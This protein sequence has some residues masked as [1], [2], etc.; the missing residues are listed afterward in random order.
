MLHDLFRHV[1]PD[2]TL[3][4]VLVY[5]CL[6]RVEPLSGEK[7]IGE[8]GLSRTLAYRLLAELVVSGL[9]KK[10][11]F[12]PVG[13]YAENPSKTFYSKA[14]T[15][16]SKLRKGREQLKKIVDNSSSLSDEEY[17]IKLDGG[18]T[19]IISL[20]T[21]ENLN[22]ETALREYRD[23]LNKKLGEIEKKKLKEWQMVG[24]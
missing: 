19:K 10:T 11:R 2:F 6:W 17:L 15:I 13:Y 24:R 12:K 1:Y 21:R 4:H 22:D 5:R 3:N 18:Q 7:V 20:Q 14:E 8:T 16:V 9:V 23:A